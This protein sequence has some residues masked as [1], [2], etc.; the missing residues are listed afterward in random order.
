MSGLSKGPK[1]PQKSVRQRRT[2]SN[3]ETSQ[4]DESKLPERPR[5]QTFYHTMKPKRAARGRSATKAR[6]NFKAAPDLR[7]SKEG[8]ESKETTKLSQ[9]NA[10]ND[11]TKSRRTTKDEGRKR[12]GS[13]RDSMSD[14]SRPL[15]STSEEEFVPMSPTRSR[16]KT[17]NKGRKVSIESSKPVII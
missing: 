7:M 9:K 13:A 16:S 3:P 4:A 6:F 12:T 8:K 5:T 11:S 17:I 2:Q 15:S 14:Y 1:S 10:C